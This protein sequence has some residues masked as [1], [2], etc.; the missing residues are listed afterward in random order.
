[1][2]AST[3]F[4]LH[5]EFESVWL[6]HV[7]DAGLARLTELLATN[8]PLLIHGSFTRACAMG[9][10]ATH[11]AWHHPRTEHLN[12]EAG[13]QWLTRVAGLNPATSAVVLAWDRTGGE[14]AIRAELLAACRREVARRA[15]AGR[16]VVRSPRP[17]AESAESFET[18]PC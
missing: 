1:M 12:D 7:T 9:C 15:T 10:L 2:A 8:S 3:S 5:A 4:D 11:I 14:W 13:V 6:P 17:G 16:A 18:C